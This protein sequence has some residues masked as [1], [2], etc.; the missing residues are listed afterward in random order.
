MIFGH[1]VVDWP[2]AMVAT[3]R[4]L[5]TV[6]SAIHKFTFMHP[7]WWITASA[8]NYPPRV[9]IRCLL[10]PPAKTRRS[11]LN[12]STGDTWQNPKYIMAVTPT[13]EELRTIGDFAGSLETPD[14]TPIRC[15]GVPVPWV[16]YELRIPFGR[17]E[18]KV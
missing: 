11:V 9:W 17:Y 10:R 1:R 6:Q 18:V 14:F 8:E 3:E 2:A 13:D 5:A 7:E 16:E 12:V 4:H 15:C